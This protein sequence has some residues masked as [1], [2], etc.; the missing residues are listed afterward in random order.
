MRIAPR[1]LLAASLAGVIIAF[2]GLV[3]ADLP[4]ATLE[5]VKVAP[6]PHPALPPGL[7]LRDASGRSTPLID[8]ADPAPRVVVFADYA[9]TTLCGPA[10]SIVGA[11]LKESGLRANADYRLEVVGLNPASTP[12]EALAFGRARL[13]P[14]ID[15]AL[16]TGD[17][18]TLSTATGA[19]GYGYAYDPTT[20]AY[21]HPV[22][23][24]VLTPNGRLTRA[25]SEVALTASSL[26]AAIQEARGGAAPGVVE[27]IALA[28]HGA[29]QAIGR[30][31]GSILLGL[32]AAALVLLAAG[33]A[34]LVALSRRRR[35]QP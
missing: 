11:R 29:L 30:F 17:A 35:P 26:R 27:S 19:L 20:K 8:A 4:R 14:D 24:F 2:A 3:H 16:L 28:C 10:L 13:P 6:P 15:A 22:A 12:S 9:C 31:D 34:A 33:A 32:R 7:S 21:A 18:A 23:A 25:L 5:Q 1:R